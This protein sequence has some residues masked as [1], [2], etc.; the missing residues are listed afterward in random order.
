MK[1]NC[2]IIS[3]FFIPNRPPRLCLPFLAGYINDLSIIFYDL[4]LKLICHKL[5][6]Q[7]K[8]ST[9]VKN[10]FGQLRAIIRGSVKFIK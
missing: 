6:L 4:A 3:P 9:A 2:N 5:S 10:S 1:F 7:P 8:K